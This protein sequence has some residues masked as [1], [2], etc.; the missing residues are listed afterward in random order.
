MVAASFAD[1]LEA[2]A[3]LPLILVVTVPLNDQT[4]LIQDIIALELELDPLR[5][6]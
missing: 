2:V 3:A 1:I 6:I 5:A 4:L